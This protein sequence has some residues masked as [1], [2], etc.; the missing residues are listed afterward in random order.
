MEISRLVCVN[1]NK[2]SPSLLFEVY[3]WESSFRVSQ[4]KQQQQPKGV[5]TVIVSAQR[6]ELGLSHYYSACT[7]E[8]LTKNEAI[9]MLVMGSTVATGLVVKKLTFQ[10]EN[11]K[12]T[13]SS[14]DT[15]PLILP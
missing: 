7:K 4:P 5:S 2:C 15:K 12:K 8:S 1:N 13:S 3:E 10:D 11:I 6:E 14:Y 9:T